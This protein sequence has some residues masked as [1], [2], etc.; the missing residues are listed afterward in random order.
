MTKKNNWRPYNEAREF[1]RRLRLS[2]TEEW[3][4]YIEHGIPGLPSR[5]SDIPRSPSYPYRAEGYGGMGD[6]LGTGISVKTEG[7]FLSYEQARRTVHSLGLR[8]K[9]DWDEKLHQ[10]RGKLGP[11]PTT[12]PTRPERYYRGRGWTGWRHFLGSDSA[13]PPAYRSFEGARNFA[14]ALGL[15]GQR[16]WHKYVKGNYRSL[17]ALPSDIPSNVQR[18]Y[19]NYGWTSWTDFLGNER[20]RA[21]Y[22]DFE[23]ARE[24]ARTLELRSLREWKAY[25]RKGSEQSPE[26][27]DDI[28]RSPDFIYKGKGWRNWGDF[29]GIKNRTNAKE[30]LSYQEARQFVERLGIT[31][32]KQWRVYARSDRPEKIPSCPNKVYAGHGWKGWPEF[33]GYKRVRGRDA[34]DEDFLYVLD[35][36]SRLADWRILAAKWMQSLVRGLPTARASVH[37][38]ITEYVIKN[39]AFSPENYLRRG[40]SFEPI[41]EALQFSKV[42]TGQAYNN[43][44]RE[45]LDW[46]IDE[47]LAPASG[48]SPVEGRSVYSNPVPIRKNERR[49]YDETHR[50]A[51][52]YRYLRMLREM[53]APGPTFR[54]WKLMHSI[55]SSDWSA[56]DE[57]SIDFDDPNYVW[58]KRTIHHNFDRKEAFERWSPVGAVAVL[59]KLLLPLRTSQVRLLESGE[60][61]TYRFESGEWK[62]N[63][64]PHARGT[65]EKPFQRGVFR[66]LEDLTTKK[67]VTGLYINTNKTQ[68]EEDVGARRGYVIPW[69]HEE[70]LYWLQLLRD[71][72]EKYNPIAGPIPWAE[73]EK[74][75]L[76]Q[77]VSATRLMRRGSATFLFRNASADHPREREKPL[78]G[79]ALHRRWY[80]ILSA[81]EARVAEMGDKLDDG[82]PIEFVKKGNTLSTYFDLHSLRV[83]LISAFALDGKVPLPILSKLVAG[84]S[85]LIMTIYYTKAGTT[86]I[87]DVMQESERRLLESEQATFRRFLKD[88]TTSTISSNFVGNELDYAV[89]VAAQSP[90][91][92]YSF[93]DIGICPTGASTCHRGFIREVDGRALPPEPVPG[94]PDER[95]CARCRY[96]L[97][98]PAFLGG[99]IARF[100]ETSYRLS[101]K[102]EEYRLATA[103]LEAAEDE[104]ADSQ[105]TD[106][107]DLVRRVNRESN[108]QEFLGQAV[109]SLAAS[110]ASIA[111]L[112]DHSRALLKDKNSG[113][114]LVKNSHSSELDVVLEESDSELRQVLAVCKAAEVYPSNFNAASLMRRSQLFDS[115]LANGGY[116]PIFSV[117]S[118]NEQ[119]AVGNHFVGL[120]E[121]RLGADKRLAESLSGSMPPRLTETARLLSEFVAGK[122]ADSNEFQG[123]VTNEV[124]ES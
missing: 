7:S 64:S 19:R 104:L 28:P 110:L 1:V 67:I 124:G 55:F 75:H 72:Q 116:R 42:D 51:L 120:L 4:T 113:L 94:Y 60:M 77:E 43:K 21:K 17:P 9:A 33:L 15:S 5:P 53:V 115:I 38:F 3:R 107:G 83:S 27:P 80:Q 29:L 13:A 34:R 36:D 49:Q 32:V 118:L 46:V 12:L 85:R 66:R 54:D 114:S 44:I 100:N 74:K 11:L 91:A 14:R 65:I 71:W 121:A 103:A 117:L 92:S 50:N 23:S 87:S 109:E 52:P 48:M 31:S 112:I 106:N 95:N 62:E 105:N 96:F 18:V 35:L 45:F 98:G 47:H 26:L 40:A 123:V 89:N 22:R 84:H 111:L 10:S 59:L 58:R 68:N 20:Q 101:Q 24:F 97:T 2:G 63:P 30:F 79:N 70:V 78:P 82:R 90:P 108:R 119:R 61:D 122:L 69:E 76:P 39:G 99:L 37:K 56:V 88:A 81:L 25:V 86:Q 8:T 41:W 6:F 102:A 16:E 57:R 93:S 73:L